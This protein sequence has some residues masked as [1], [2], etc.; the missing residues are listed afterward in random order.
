MIEHYKN[1]DLA[2][3]VYTNEF[4]IKCTEIWKDIPRFEGKYMASNLSRVK[5]VSR[6]VV[7]K[8]GS[9]TVKECIL[10]QWIW[11]KGSLAVTL[12]S[13]DV[14][15]KIKIHKLMI[16]VFEGIEL[17]GYERIIDHIDNNPLNNVLTNLQITTPRHNTSKDKNFETKSS[18][19]TGVCWNKKAEKWQVSMRFIGNKRTSHLHQTT[20][21]DLAG[22]F[23]QTAV[24]NLDRFNGNIADF[25]KLI[26]DILNIKQ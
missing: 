6:T 21:E 19:Y 14:R 11:S 2:D 9:Y 26:K 25:R 22:L 17:V 24:E 7:R 1:L 4:G 5:S 12:Y 20:D 23:Y 8:Q 16:W 3:I 13:G 10:K 18:K 15:K